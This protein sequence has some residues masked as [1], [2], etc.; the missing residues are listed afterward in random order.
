MPINYIMPII[1]R[2]V[3]TALYVWCLLTLRNSINIPSIKGEFSS[4]VSQSEKQLACRALRLSLPLQFNIVV[5][6]I[7][8]NNVLS[9][10]C[11]FLIAHFKTQI[12]VEHK[13]DQHS[14]LISTAK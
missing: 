10:L 14:I 11:T 13:V 4:Y 1:Y 3:L 5:L 2:A 12:K 8:V 9:I 6:Q 7:N